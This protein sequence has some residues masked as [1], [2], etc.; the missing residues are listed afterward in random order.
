M[1]SNVCFD[2]KRF[3]GIK[4]DY[5]EKDVIGT[6]CICDTHDVK[7]SKGFCSNCNYGLKRFEYNID[8]LRKSVL[9]LEDNKL[10]GTSKK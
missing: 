2:L 8:T 3:S 6:C 7:L 9:Y 1:K 10:T 5:S 4:R